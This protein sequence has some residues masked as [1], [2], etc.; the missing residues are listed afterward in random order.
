MVGVD[1]VWG[2]SLFMCLIEYVNECESAGVVF[3]NVIDITDDERQRLEFV[4]VNFCKFIF[5]KFTEFYFGKRNRD[6]PIF[7]FGKKL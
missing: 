1:P 7:Y 2:R 5:V 6:F 3:G 4:F